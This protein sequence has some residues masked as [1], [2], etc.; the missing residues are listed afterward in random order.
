[1]KWLI[2]IALTALTCPRTPWGDP[3]LQGVWSGLDSIGVP[4][5]RDPALGT[6]NV[7][8]QEEFERRQEAFRTNASSDN[9]EATNF[10]RGTET[11]VMRNRSRQASLVVDP[12]DGRR[13]P[14]TPESDARQPSTFGSFSPGPFNSVSDL[15]VFDR[16]IA[17]SP[18]SSAFAFNTLQIVQARDY[19]AIR[20]EVLDEVRIVPLDG[21]SHLPSGF[22]TYSGDSRGR[23]E[24][25]T[26]V[27]TT[28]NFNGRTDLQGNAGGRASERLTVTERFTVA[29]RN[30][31][32]YEATFDDPGTW[33]RPWTVAFPRTR[34]AAGAVYEYA[35]HDGNYGLANILRAARAAE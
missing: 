30:T 7:L 23:W 5:D 29:D 8:T 2:A 14:R 27:V 24:G 34:D 1:M 6:R 28:T 4:L 18:M 32:T 12:P 3:D 33:T 21:R 11:E 22:K 19:V 26:L 10:G 20:T 13:P 31:L 16:C 17:Y 9:I 25:R 15:G 35:C